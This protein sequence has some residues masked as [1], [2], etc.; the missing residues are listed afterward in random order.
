MKTHML[1]KKIHSWRIISLV[2]LVMFG[3]VALPLSGLISDD[4]QALTPQEKQACY[5][6]WNNK[7]VNIGR[8]LGSDQQNLSSC[9]ADNFCKD[10]GAGAEIDSRK[11]TCTNPSAADPGTTEAASD[12]ETKPLITLICGTAPTS[13]DTLIDKYVTCSENVKKLYASCSDTGGG[14]TGSGQDTP[15]NTAKCMYPKLPNPK[16]TQLKIKDAIVTGRGAANTITTDAAQKKACEDK[17]GTWANSKCTEKADAEKDKST[18]VLPGIGWIVCPIMYLMGKLVDSAYSFVTTLLKVPALVLTGNSS[19]IYTGWT[20]MRNFSNVAFVIVFLIIIFSQL[21]N[22]GVTNYGIKKMLPRLIVAAILVNISYWIC[23]VAVD[24]SNISGSAIFDLFSGIGSNITLPNSGAFG[25]DGKGWEAM[26]GGTLAAGGAI[27]AGAALYTSLA[28]L[29]PALVA[30]LFAIVTVFLVLTLRQAL[31]ILL[32]VVSPLAF[33]AYLLPNTESLFKK[34]RGLLQTLL[35]MYPIVAG[36]FGVSALASKIIMSADGAS[37]IVKIMGALI[38]ILPLAITPI[39]LKTAGGVLN[40]FGGIINNPK[41]GPFDRMRKGAEGLRDYRKDIVKTNRAERAR[42]IIGGSGGGLGSEGSKRRRTA[43]WIAGVG[44]T[45]GINKEQREANAKKALAEGRQGYVA[46]RASTDEQYAE[47]IAG[48]T[49]DA[50]LVSIAA[51]DAVRQEHMENVKRQ[52]AQYRSAGHTSDTLV[53]MAGDGSLS[54]VEREAAM[55]EV[56]ATGRVASVMELT[57]LMGDLGRQR[58]AL[59]DPNGAE[60]QTLRD[61]MQTASTSIGTSKGKPKVVSGSSLEAGRE[62][63]FTGSMDTLTD[64]YLTDE[65][66]GKEKLPDMDIDELLHLDDMVAT[67]RLSITP[68]RRAATS[69]AIDSL[70]GQADPTDPTGTKRV[71]ADPILSAKLENR[72]IKALERIRAGL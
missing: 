36:I 24:L 10:A 52:R 27:A 57:N 20:I 23:A 70:I 19:G 30:A 48:P 25:A 44:T 7:E 47:H 14:I 35:L 39:I 5:D 28:A 6:R 2:A 3:A 29:L 67:G 65:K 34:W 37:N 61:L 69:A 31:I 1:L 18:C 49:G 45:A 16:P 41:K 32:I 11:I 8:L 46:E 26:V 56:G 43:A 42:G 15:E 51:Q 72:Q 58:Q 71:N 40:R 64:A 55:E 38:A 4:A 62:G 60:G 9:R 50:A 33:V 68:E 66:V 13:G 12:A 54:Q 53:G 17:G 59:A 22:V 21:T 63:T